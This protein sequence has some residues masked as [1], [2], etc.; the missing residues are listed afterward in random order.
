MFWIDGDVD[1]FFEMGE[2]ILSY[3]LEVVGKLFVEIF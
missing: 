3:G 1:L 2:K